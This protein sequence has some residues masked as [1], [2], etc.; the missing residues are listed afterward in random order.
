MTRW[1]ILLAAGLALAN[2]ADAAAEPRAQK[3]QKAPAAHELPLHMYL[4]KGEANACGDGCGMW[5]AVEG[6]FD[7]GAAGRVN[8]FLKRHAARKL[9]VYFHS[10][11]GS[12]RDALA[13]GRQLRQLGLTT[14]VGRTVPRGCASASDASDACRAAKRSP[15]PV[16]AEW[17]P[18][19][20]CS[21]A[22]VWAMIGGKVRQ[23]PPAARLGVHSGRLTLFRKYSDGR[24]QQ[25]SSKEAPSLHKTR[26]AA[27]DAENRRYIREM[28]IDGALFDRTLKVAHE[29]IYHLSRNEIAAFG[30]DRREFVE[31]PWFFS[32]FSSGTSYVNKWIVEARGTERKEYRISIAFLRCSGA[33]HI[34]I[35]YVRGVASDEV[36]QPTT[37]TFSLGER[38]STLFFR[39]KATKR[40]TIDTGA[41]FV[42]GTNDVPFEYV[43]AAAAAEA[44][45]VVESGYTSTEQ[46][47]G[48]KLSTLGLAEGV[49]ALREK[50]TKPVSN[51]LDGTQAPSGLPQNVWNPKGLHLPPD[52]KPGGKR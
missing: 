50:C 2:A 5:I 31:T 39:G 47:R 29:D 46:N 4:A 33:H 12:S 34:S 42:S 16:A 43:E 14:G 30:I 3:A 36:G 48:I 35:Q 13:V 45:N 24:V 32:Q 22:C 28:G 6:R 41:L 52:W 40:D 17:R 25:L 9:P 37:A 44:I 49:K 19:G 27:F 11:G 1:L 26:A 10:P 7:A 20:I 38:K 15:Q 21:S 8:A 51:A 23:V 18:D